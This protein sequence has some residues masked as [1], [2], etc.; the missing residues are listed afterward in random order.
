MFSGGERLEHQRGSHIANV[1]KYLQGGE[2]VMKKLQHSAASVRLNNKE[3][4]GIKQNPG[5][6]A[7]LVSVTV[8]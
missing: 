3:Y 8:I 7:E 4:D 2:K 6:M 1:L 5:I